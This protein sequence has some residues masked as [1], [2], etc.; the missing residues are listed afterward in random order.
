M[1]PRYFARS[2]SDKDD[3]WPYWFVADRE[4]G[5]LNVTA[6]LVR[7]HINPNHH[8]A[9]LCIPDFAREIAALANEAAK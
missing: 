3:N 6:D 9:T 1:N 2:A 7:K 4:R 5:G 8:G